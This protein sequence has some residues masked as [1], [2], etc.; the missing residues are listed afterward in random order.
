MLR[1]SPLMMTLLGLCLSCG[2]DAGSDTA[3]DPMTSP[4]P[5]RE[6]DEPGE[7]ADGVDNDQDGLLDCEDTDC[8][9]AEACVAAYRSRA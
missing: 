9:G 3:D 8:V 2:G 7:C 5:Q 1:M 6:G 4:E